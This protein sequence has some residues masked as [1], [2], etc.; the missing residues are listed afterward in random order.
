MR[1]AFTVIL[2]FLFVAAFA[3][4]DISGTQIYNTNSGNVGIGTSTPTAKLYVA[5]SFYATEGIAGRQY[6]TVTGS[7]GGGYRIALNGQSDGYIVGRNEG[8]ETKFQLRTDGI[9]FLNGGNVGIGTASPDEKLTVKGTI[10]SEEVKVD[11]SVPAPDY[12][13]EDDYP[14]LSLT[15]V[16]AFIKMNKHLPEIPSGSTMEHA[17]INL[18]EMNLLLL[19]KIEELTLHLIDKN[20]QLTALTERVEILEKQISQ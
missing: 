15:E 13:F 3:Q 5:G 1:I 16:A 6:I 7:A 11:L 12:V 4:W 17:G 10:H 19:K 2:S 8:L 18:G 9:S 14:L 20:E